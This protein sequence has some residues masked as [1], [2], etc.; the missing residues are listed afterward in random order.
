M[1]PYAFIQT[2]YAL[3]PTSYAFTYVFV[4]TWHVLVIFRTD[5]ACFRVTG[6]PQI[7]IESVKNIIEAMNACGNLK[8]KI[9]FKA[10]IVNDK[11]ENVILDDFIAEYI[12]IKRDQS[13]RC[14]TC[15]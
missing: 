1:V 11:I 8:R 9:N 13:Q 2:W 5:S 3:V 14:G 7:P 15:S 12:A 10:I 6:I 4:R